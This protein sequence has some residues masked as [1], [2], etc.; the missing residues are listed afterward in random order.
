MA[1][2]LPFAVTAQPRI[3][4]TTGMIGD[5]VSAIVG[6]LATVEVLLATGIDPHTYRLNRQDVVRLTE[7]DI[8]IYNGGLLEGRMTDTLRQFAERKLVISVGDLLDPALH[9]ASEDYPGEYDPHLWMDVRRWQAALQAL[10]QALSAAYPQYRAQFLVNRTAYDQQLL[11]LDAYIRQIVATL[12]PERR[13]L[14][15]A[16][17]AFQYFADAYQFEVHGIQGV[18]TES[19]ANLQQVNALI[20]LIV[21]RQIPAVFAESSVN[22][23]QVRALIEG[24]TARGQPVRLG[25]ELFSDAMGEPGTYEGTYLGMIDHNATAIVRALG[26]EAP[27]GGWQGSLTRNETQ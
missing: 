25:S 3:V 23:R 17:D 10:E 20:D 16:H 18:S 7:A 15:T 6:D 24:A 14:I 12:P 19:E 11:Q 9:L 1:I 5:S 26:G 22:D 2:L 4:A 8:I 21:T 13:V 27:V